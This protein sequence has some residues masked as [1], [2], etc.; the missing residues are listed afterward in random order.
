MATAMFGD[1]TFAI[2]M[3][4]LSLVARLA[5]MVPPPWQNQVRYSGVLAPAATW[6]S[7]VVAL[8]P[9][10]GV[11]NFVYGRDGCGCLTGT[12]CAAT[13]VGRA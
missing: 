6:R 3:D 7:R 1:G 10:E 4:E 12:A 5:A 9:G 13:R 2:E 11:R 8:A